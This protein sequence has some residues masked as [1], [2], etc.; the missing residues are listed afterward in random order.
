MRRLIECETHGGFHTSL[1]TGNPCTL[2]KE[3]KDAGFALLE[4]VGQE[5]VGAGRR[6]MQIR[7]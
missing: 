6:P 7:N 1:G 4:Q 2:V 3:K 5:I